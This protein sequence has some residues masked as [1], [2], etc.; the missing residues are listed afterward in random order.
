MD[1]LEPCPFCGG[2]AEMHKKQASISVKCTA[3]QW[4]MQ[5]ISSMNTGVEVLL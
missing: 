1:K 4:P 2:E 5:M 3:K